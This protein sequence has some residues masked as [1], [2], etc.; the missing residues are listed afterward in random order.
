MER[1]YNPYLSQKENAGRVRRLLMSI[2]KANSAK[3]DMAAYYEKHETLYGYKGQS[4][5]SIEN[6]VRTS[7]DDTVAQDGTT[8][9]LDEWD[10]TEDET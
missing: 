6:D 2:K 9:N 3:R 7:L 4:L 10:V 8:I 5:A 1:A